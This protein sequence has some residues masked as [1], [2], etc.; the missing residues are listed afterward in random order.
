MYSAVSKW[1][2]GWRRPIPGYQKMILK[3]EFN[4]K[5]KVTPT[6]T[7][8]VP[9]LKYSFDIINWRLEGIQNFEEKWKDTDNV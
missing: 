7:W 9:V 5:N 4:A 8:T 1:K 6:G 3:S 2:E